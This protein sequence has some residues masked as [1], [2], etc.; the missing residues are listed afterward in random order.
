MCSFIIQIHAD[1][2]HMKCKI[3]AFDQRLGQPERF[4][5]PHSDLIC[6]AATP[7]GSYGLSQQRGQFWQV[8]NY[9]TIQTSNQVTQTLSQAAMYPLS[10]TGEPTEDAVLSLKQEVVLCAIRAV[11]FQKKKQV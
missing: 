8:R 2:Y 9:K 11:T 1:S 6:E 4:F 10:H 7:P 3:L 5:F